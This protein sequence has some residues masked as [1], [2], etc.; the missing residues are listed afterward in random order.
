M[1]IGLLFGS[2]NPI[3]KGH[4]AIARYFLENTDLERIWF[5]VSPRN[6]LKKRNELLPASFRAEMVSDSLKGS[7]KMRVE[8]IEFSLPVPSYTYRTLRKL[9]IKFPRHEFSIIMGADSLLTLKKWKNHENLLKDHRIFI[10]PRKSD[11]KRSLLSHPNLLFSKAPIMLFSS[12]EI[13]SK[14][15]NGKDVSKHV[16]AAVNRN[17]QKIRRFLLD[18]KL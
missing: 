1:K 2:F 10:Y 8:R 16:P 15:A 3:H 6:P 18:I 14:I 9:R 12:T 13:R 7:K 11:S 5:V 4:I 17:I